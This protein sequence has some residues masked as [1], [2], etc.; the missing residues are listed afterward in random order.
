MSWSSNN[1]DD[2]PWGKSSKD[3]KKSYNGSGSTGDGGN[4][5][6]F[7]NIQ[8]RLK[9][10]FP[11]KNP[12]SLSLVLLII[13]G[14]WAISGFYRVGTDEQG[15]VTRFGQYVR[16][17]EPGLHYHLPFPVESVFTYSGFISPKSIE[18]SGPS[19][20]SKLSKCIY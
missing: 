5:D 9:K 2:S 12:A 17:T 13:L 7:K 4:D 11:N 14:F 6:P 3:S 1:D 18:P 16:T 8:D 19:S 20:G 10:F 15:V